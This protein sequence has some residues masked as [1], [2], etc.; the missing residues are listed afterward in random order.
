M[1]VYARICGLNVLS[2]LSIPGLAGSQEPVDVDLE[3]R[4]GNGH[5]WVPDPEQNEASTFLRWDEK[6]DPLLEVSRHPDGNYF[7]LA[8]SDG[9]AFTIDGSGRRVWGTWQAPYSLDYAATYLLGPVLGLVL[10]RRGQVSLHASAFNHEGAAVAMAGPPGAGKSTTVTAFARRGF[11]VLT[12]DMMPLTRKGTT[13]LAQPSYPR[14]RLWH[15]S[16]S[17][18]YG[19]E[20]ALPPL[21]PEWD[22]KALDL[23]EQGLAFESRPLPLKVVYFLRFD[24]QHTTSEIV[25]LRGPQALMA[26]VNNTYVNYMLDQEMRAREFAL[27]GPLLQAVHLRCFML[28][29]PGPR[30]DEICDLILR[31]L[32]SFPESMAA[33]A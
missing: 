2:N 13:F 1:P 17:D 20:D 15:D 6:G 14:L 3:V 23:E 31:D 11:S 19:S 33:G 8:Y 5:P 12:D 32:D 27:L 10:R 24:K 21:A 30:P 7:R 28:C 22:K 18:F 25:P 29:Q 4:L 9:T 26:L 16:V